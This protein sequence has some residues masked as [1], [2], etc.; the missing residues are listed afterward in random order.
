MSSVDSQIIVSALAYPLSVT[1]LIGLVCIGVL[2]RG[3]VRLMQSRQDS[4]MAELKNN[5]HQLEGQIARQGDAI[6]QRLE[7]WSRD[8]QVQLVG[9]AQQLKSVNEAVGS[10]KTALVVPHLRGRI[11]G[12]T[13]LERLLGD[14]LPPH[15]YSFQCKIGDATANAVIRFP[16]I[17]LICPVD[18]TFD[19]SSAR[20]LL[21]GHADPEIMA[22]SRRQLAAEVR[23]KAEE[24]S[25]SLIRPELGTTDFAY[26][27]VSSEGIFQEILHDIELWQSLVADR[28][29]VVSPHTL[30]VALQPLSHA[31]RYYEMSEGVNDKIRILQDA[32]QKL[33]EISAQ[34]EEQLQKS[35]HAVGQ[36]RSLLSLIPSV[37]QAVKVPHYG[38]I[39]N[40]SADGLNS[41]GFVPSTSG[42]VRQGVSIC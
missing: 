19:F 2:L 17:G 39:R 28:V 1:L 9:Q 32:G 11:L 18:C 42:D 13:T 4:K 38:E 41:S 37:V 7:S 3:W 30:F 27:F 15:G 33:A 16:H 35:V 5:H 23:K 40:P 14:V 31:I 22:E 26:L 36:T 21:E 24:I 34:V 25:F 10:L 6:A 29:L 8:V 20:T 12:E